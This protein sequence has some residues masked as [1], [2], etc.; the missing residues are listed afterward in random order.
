MLQGME[1]FGYVV[2]WRSLIGGGR[3][4]LENGV[5]AHGGS[6]VHLFIQLPPR[7]NAVI[8][9]TELAHLC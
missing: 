6:T 2:D 4:I 5:I 7:E 9:F 1:Y 8:T 3:F